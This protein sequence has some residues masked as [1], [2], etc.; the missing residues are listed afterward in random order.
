MPIYSCEPVESGGCYSARRRLR[1]HGKLT[2]TLLAGRDSESLKILTK[3]LVAERSSSRADSSSGFDLPV[4]V[5]NA[6]VRQ[7]VD[8]FDI[9]SFHVPTASPVDDM[10]SM[11]RFCFEVDARSELQHL[12]WH[13]V[14]PPPRISVPE[15]VSKVLAPFVPALSDYLATQGVTLA[16]FPFATYSANIVS[17]FATHVM[18]RTPKD[19]IGNAQIGCRRQKCNDCDILRNFFRSDEQKMSLSRVG[20]ARTHLQNQQETLPKSWGIEFLLERQNKLHISKPD[21]MTI[22]GLWAEN[23]RIPRVRRQRPLPT[24]VGRG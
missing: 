18:P 9:S 21:N 5:V 17:T 12:L 22:A 11:V 2:E 7:T 10:I 14:T 23:H 19:L 16:A 1:F 15:H 3:H 20:K 6:L 4:W 13:F 24:P 8:V